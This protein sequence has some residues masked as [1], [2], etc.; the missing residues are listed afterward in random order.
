MQNSAESA[1]YGG[2]LAENWPKY[3]E[4][5]LFS[6]NR[7]YLKTTGNLLYGVRNTLETPNLDQGY[8]LEISLRLQRDF[9][10]FSFFTHF[11]GHFSP[12]GGVKIATLGSK[13]TQKGKKIKILKNPY[14]ASKIFL[15]GISGPNLGF[16]G[17]S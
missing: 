12:A 13:I 16:L 3:R 10:K 5:P 4:I 15:K 7:E 9:S 1:F 14:L 6:Q 11:F 8:L 17:Y 2:F